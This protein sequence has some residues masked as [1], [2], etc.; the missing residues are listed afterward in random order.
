MNIMDA[1]SPGSGGRRRGRRTLVATCV[2]ATIAASAL[3]GCGK[4]PPTGP[5]VQATPGID[6][7]YRG[8]A[9]PKTEI[10]AFVDFECPYTRG[11]AKGLLDLSE[12]HKEH[13][14]FRFL[15]LPLDVHPN[16]VAAARGAVAA[17]R[18]K[19][20][21]KFFATMME[22]KSVSR[23][24]IIAWAVEA[25]LDAKKF[26]AD[27]DSAETWASIVRDAGIAKALG[28]SGTPSFVVNGS[29][30][31]GAQPQ[32][33]WERKIAEEVTK[34]AGLTA[35]GT[36]S[37]GLLRAMVAAG[38]PKGA[39]EYLGM[40]YDGK[41]PPK[42]DVPTKV[43]R[44]S[45]IESAQ[46]QAAPAGGA[47]VQIGEMPTPTADD[48]TTVWRAIIRPDDPRLGP[49]TALATA[50]VFED[51]Q[52][53]YCAKLRPTL[54]K[55]VDDYKGRL[56]VVFKHNPLPTHEHAMGAAEA[57]EAARTQGKFW[58]M[59]DHLLQHQDRLDA[60]GLA[61]AATTVGLDKAQF[62]TAMAAHGARER[63][64]ADVDQ[65]AALGARGT[66]NLYING[67]KVVGAKDETFLKPIIDTAIAAA[68][69]LVK[70]GT[71][72]DKV[73]EAATA[74]GKL[75]DS[76]EPE[77][78]TIDLP[79]QTPTRGPIGASIH[80]VTFQDFQCPFSARLDPHIRA[81]EGEFPG[82]V[83]VSWVDWPNAKIHP[84]AQ[85][86]AEAGREA[87]AQ[88][89]FWEFHKA[90]MANN[91]RLDDAVLR[92]R[93]KAAGVDLR[94]LD[95]ALADRSHTSAVET[96]KAL[97]DKLGVL[98]TPTVFINGHL[99]KP[100]SFSADTFRVAMRRLL[101]SP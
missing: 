93:A 61:D 30:Y 79:A 45:G 3:I 87:Q 73:Y 27:M 55:L 2:I 20:Y 69:E 49:E 74:K 78:K 94:K 14:K 29:L 48:P 89:K 36:P 90:V 99:F 64:E 54:R 51:M 4:K 5:A 11:A 97:G 17:H 28:V 42:A 18:H 24:S 80:I 23:E 88:G 59:H 43:A 101:P 70:A 50:V 77:A 62:A 13:V 60:A 84:L 41:A 47:A 46:I 1:S 65:A 34:A 56:R 58:E 82:R 22:A 100:Q 63:I 86:F 96:A 16:A 57:L 39:V 68:Q 32:E 53:P 26:V 7:P 91:D 38:N 12:K 8:P 33:F 92:E 83:K 98:G 37:A 71:A 81:I 76:L 9:E 19:A 67:K 15:N 52:C 85:R 95:K 21:F 25:G 10:L 6:T 35:A 66:P 40:L 31:Q 72:P 44:A 75:L